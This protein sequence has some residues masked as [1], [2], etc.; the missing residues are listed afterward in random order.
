MQCH[1]QCQFISYFASNEYFKKI[2]MIGQ[3]KCVAYFGLKAFF[4]VQ[5][6]IFSMF[7]Y[8]NYREG[9]LRM[10]PVL[11]QQRD[12]LLQNIWGIPSDSSIFNFCWPSE[13]ILILQ[14]FN[15]SRSSRYL[16]QAC[17]FG[18]VNF[19]SKFSFD[20]MRPNSVKFWYW[21]CINYVRLFGKLHYH[22]RN[23]LQF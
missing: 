23:I 12:Q 2:V 7:L 20:M 13:V 3:G 14:C 17:K 5:I 9:A 15:F 4:L 16:T 19:N 8:R 21:D 11:P 6:L 18:Y 10:D 1:F 22:A